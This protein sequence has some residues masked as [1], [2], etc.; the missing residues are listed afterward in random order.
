LISQFIGESLLLTVIAVALALGLALAALGPFAR[1]VERDIGLGDVARPD[2]V[3]AIVAITLLVAIGAGS[4]PAFLLSSVN[5]IRA[6]RG[7]AARGTTAATFRKLLVVLQF[8]ISIA[9]IVATLVVF[10]QQRFA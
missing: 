1:F 9:L 8:A 7:Q 4:Y 3:A 2:V 6:L 5:P 10:N